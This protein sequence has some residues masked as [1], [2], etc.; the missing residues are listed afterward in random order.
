[1][2]PFV[3]L[4]QLHASGGKRTL[5]GL[6]V[7][8][9]VLSSGTRASSEGSPEKYRGFIHPAEYT[10][11]C[12]TEIRRKALGRFKRF[13]GSTVSG[14]FP[15][16]NLS[17]RRFYRICPVGYPPPNPASWLLL[18]FRH[19][20]AAFCCCACCCS[21]CSCSWCSVDKCPRA[22]LCV[23][24]ERDRFFLPRNRMKFMLE[25]SRIAFA[26]AQFSY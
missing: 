20:P 4:G 18:H 17:P 16:L 23:C 14:A 9:S 22:H 2:R 10:F 11:A 8:A 6:Y 19:A 13:S 3:T 26:S 12:P 1:M 21:S 15:S 7:R 5:A 25:G 24:N